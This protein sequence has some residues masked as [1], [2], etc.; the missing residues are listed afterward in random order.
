MFKIL[1][2]AIACV[3][4]ILFSDLLN[5]QYSTSAAI[6]TFLTI[7]DTK[8]E[9]IS[10]SM[11]R[12]F[13][14]FLAS[15]IAFITFSF[16]GYSAITFGIFMFFFVWCTYTLKLADT[17]STSAVIGTHYLIAASFSL[18][19]FFNEFMIM[20]I[21][22]GIGTIIN[23]FM[24]RYIK[25]IQE[26]Q[27]VIEDDMQAILRMMAENILK[28]SKAD[29]NHKS[30]EPLLKDIQKG[31]TFAYANMNNTFMQESKY[32]ISYME[33][34]KQQCLILE[35]I[36]EQ[37]GTLQIIL[38]QTEEVARLL[39]KLAHTLHHFDNTHDLLLVCQ[40]FEDSFHNISLPKNRIEFETCATLYILSKDLFYF[41]EMKEIF[42]DSVTSSQK[43]RYWR[44]L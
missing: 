21:G 20:L 36:Y 30:F 1:K 27:H 35:N 26:I 4:S 7:Q 16:F 6:I 43:E 38:P 11:K 10:L 33:M 5:L 2:I 41:L 42:A 8:K 3:L 15:G 29:Y 31:I 12:M 40:D 14:F 34:R 23:L 28:E 13:S 17:I 19:F 44:V 37:I 24:P 39:T 32:F 9:T 22:V 25:K 18:N